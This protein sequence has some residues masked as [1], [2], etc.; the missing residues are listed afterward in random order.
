MFTPTSNTDLVAPREASY[1]LR[2]TCRAGSGIVAAVT[3]CLA[4]NDCYIQALEQFD[5]EST[6][7]FFMR[8]VFKR[9]ANSPELAA[10]QSHLSTI[11]EKFAIEFTIHDPAQPLKVVVMV[12]KDDHCLN[13]LLYRKNKGELNIQITAVVSNHA[14]LRA[15]VEREGI[16]FIQLPIT[17]E[18]KPHQEQ[19]LLEI[20]DETAAEL[21][22]LARYMQILSDPLCQQLSGRCINIHHSFLPGFKGARPYHQAFNRGVKLIGATAHYVTPDLDEGPIIEQMVTRVDHNQ[23]PHMLAALG[24]ENESMALTR[25]V[26][27]HVEQRV[28][29][30]GNKTVV[31]LGS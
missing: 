25:A 20:I 4:A 19:R 22:V 18:N 14:D 27:Y 8:A 11:A 24:R 7:K 9:Q 10:I 15:M 1:I 12:S 29:L 28:F 13:A 30:D 21:V 26:R 31:F 2:A 6:D 23:K 5:D 16:R 3:G 17:P